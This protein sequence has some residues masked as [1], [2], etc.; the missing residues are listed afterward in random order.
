MKPSD[1]NELIVKSILLAS[2]ILPKCKFNKFTKPYRTKDV[3][4]AYKENKRLRNTWILEGKPRGQFIKSYREYK[5]AKSIFRRQQRIESAKYINH[6]F[7]ELEKAA[8]IDYKLFWK[9]L[10]N[11]K[12]K[13]TEI[14]TE[15]KFNE[16]TYA[17]EKIG[18][19]FRCYFQDIFNDNEPMDSFTQELKTKMN[20]FSRTEPKQ[21]EHILVQEVTEKISR[22]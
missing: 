10:R 13:Q 22:T 19:G 3:K 18:E 1:I 20:T 15:L 12:S 9:L 11:K 16:K 17:D 6:S 14:C 4:I 2:E 21:F 5:H 8:E 7:E